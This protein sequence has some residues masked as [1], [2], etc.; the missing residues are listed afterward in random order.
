MANEG[1]ELYV[2]SY[3]NPTTL[4]GVLP[5]RI[6][7]QY[8]EPVNGLGGGSF[9]VA[10]TDPKL[11]DHPG[12][13]DY[14]NRVVIRVDGNVIGSFI[15]RK[16]GVEV[17]ASKDKTQE[18][19]TM[20]GDSLIIW[21]EDAGVRPW[22]GLKANSPSSRY[23]SFASEVG[24]WYNED[25]WD[26]PSILGPV[27][28]VAQWGAL[29][30]KWP[31]G[32]DS[33]W[34]WSD[35]YSGEATPGTCYFR[36]TLTISTAGEYSL[37]VAGDD[38]IE[39]FVDGAQV[40][41]SNYKDEA[42]GQVTKVKLA[43]DSGVH[44][45]GFKATVISGPAGIIEALYH[46][47]GDVETKVASSSDTN[48]WKV[49]AYP[50]SAPGW[51][52]GEIMLTLLEEAEDRGVL[53][54]TWITPTFTN[55]HDS[56]SVAWEQAYEWQFNIDKDSIL[57]ALNRILELGY[58]AWIDPETLEF[59][60]VISRGSNKATG[61]SALIFERGKN[62]MRASSEGVG[63]IKNSLAVKTA[64]GWLLEEVEHDDSVTEYGVIEG[65]LEANVSADVA[66]ALVQTVFTHR[67]KA[68][69]G[70]SYEIYPTQD[71][72]P[73]DK[74]M[75]GDWVLAPNDREEL[76]PRR[77][78]SI[79][80]KE[81]SQGQPLYTVELDTIFQSN[82]QILNK[83]VN[84]QS[85]GGLGSNFS[86]AIGNPSFGNPI[87]VTPSGPP[88]KYPKA[89][90]GLD[91]TSTGYWS[92]NGM[93]ALSEVVITWNAVTENTDETPLTPLGYRVWAKQSAENG[94]S[95][96][97]DITDEE[98]TIRGLT[99]NT[100]WDFVVQTIGMGNRTSVFSDVLTLTT[101]GPTTPMDPPDAPTL[102]SN[103]GLLVVTWN[104]LINGLAPPPQFRYVYAAVSPDGVE[105]AVPMGSTLGREGGDIVI[106]GL[107]VG[108]EP[109]VS[110]I[111]VDGANIASANSDSESIEIIGI[112]LGDL[113]ESIQE[114]I[115]AAY[116]AAIN[117]R[118]ST[119]LLEDNS[120]E[121]GTQ[122]FWTWDE[123]LV[124]NVTG[125][126][127]TGE[128]SLQ[129]TASD[130]PYE[131]FR[132]NRAI[133]CDPGMSYNYRLYV[134]SEDNVDL[135][136]LELVIASGSTEDDLDTQTSLAFSTE[137]TETYTV[138]SGVWLVPE[139]TYYFVPTLFVVD[140]G[141][142]NIYYID[143]V[144][145][146]TMVDTSLVVDGAIVAE[147]LAAGSVTAVALAA[148]SVA[149]VNIQASAVTADKLAANSVT[150][151]AI[152]AG[153][154]EANAISAGAI[155]VSHLSPSV[156]DEIDISA[157][158]TITII[159]GSIGEVA[160]DLNN[161]QGT[162]ETMQTY[163][164]FGPS[165]AVIS[166]PG[167]PFAVAIRNDRIEM[168]ENSNP[169]SYW[170]SGQMNVLQLVGETVILGNHKIERHPTSGTVV[171][172]L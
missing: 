10:I 123:D 90:T 105:P 60:I 96:L 25:D 84:K 153:S 37:Y 132:Y 52:P 121:L 8:L 65:T 76:V 165:G 164:E 33:D 23:F 137:L 51:S 75:V 109:V 88:A 94:Y 114:A 15:I 106:S 99:P 93:S 92:A 113:D 98:V 45:I 59:H 171:K 5:G 14:R 169:V 86:N 161:T 53:F 31:E 47:D 91:Y 36:H 57:T 159:S 118:S 68:E 154:I 26:T 58:E 142:T 112:D 9:K 20:A 46:I 170:N 11:N 150:A 124:E 77:V 16:K 44:Y 3:K 42:Y 71:E 155:Q 79:S 18:L 32:D 73:F 140:S 135:E 62:L 146:F 41:T 111:A 89:P 29:P 128:R 141:E 139:D 2:Y 145:V 138:F 24:D 163:Y 7:P 157:N 55:T 133:P 72:T 149:A 13:L 21:L 152:A 70:A 119:N 116:E 172:A 102:T 129:V 74:L 151:N 83:V 166:T 148:E 69:E 63:S 27:Y 4:I 35:V 126:A 122:E 110:L 104:G 87:P 48:N 22:G 160:S 136:G 38:F 50:S 107:I 101:T 120:F 54:P 12:I 100:S 40:I 147:H 66:K 127:R 1:I 144:R 49:L 28:E 64:E 97:N 115:D 117:A 158:N 134:K 19:Y 168:L 34:I 103:K 156:G 81:N 67:A 80:L 43:L 167:S 6:D 56:N 95:P 130:E 162:L 39:V 17:I 78:V 61:P 30:E 108:S 82:E 85:G 131:A 125:E 143:D